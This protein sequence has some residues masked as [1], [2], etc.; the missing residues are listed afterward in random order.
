MEVYN[1]DTNILDVSDKYNNHYRLQLKWDKTIVKGNSGTGKTHL[2]NIIKAI[3]ESYNEEEYNADNIVLLTKENKE[4][5]KIIK[6]KLVIIDVADL[7]LD[8]KDVEFINRDE[9]N[10]YIIYTRVPIGLALSPNHQAD[11]VQNGNM[12]SLKYRFNVRGWC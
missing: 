9:D 7:L 11:L 2:F 4:S 10:R 12:T 5:L 3:K 6:N 1:W 8:D